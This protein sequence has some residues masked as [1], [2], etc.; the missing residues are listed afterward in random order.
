MS[1][2]A[3]TMILASAIAFSISFVQAC[4]VDSTGGGKT[5]MSAPGAPT[6]GGNSQCIDSLHRAMKDFR[7][8]QGK[9]I[10][11]LRNKI[12]VELLKPKPDRRLLASCIAQQSE[13]RTKI[14]DR[15]LE[16]MLKIK[17]LTKGDSFP[18]YVKGNWGCRCG[19]SDFG[20]V[21][22]KEAEGELKD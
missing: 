4:P 3:K 14:A 16:S 5:S 22:K 10:M 7:A 19:D 9:K 1:M 20:C 17:S 13:L 2:K 6:A 15:W 18:Q 21:P 11:E 8:Q 12:D